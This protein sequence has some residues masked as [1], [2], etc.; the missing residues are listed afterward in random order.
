MDQLDEIICTIDN[1]KNINFTCPSSSNN[2]LWFLALS[3]VFQV[4]RPSMTA[5]RAEPTQMPTI[6]PM[7]VESNNNN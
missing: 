3:M 4:M 5:I 2:F 6:M 7:L 1:T